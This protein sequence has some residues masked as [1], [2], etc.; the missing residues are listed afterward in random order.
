MQVL[1]GW[2]VEEYQHNSAAAHTNR[3]ENISEDCVNKSFLVT[4]LKTANL[5][6]DSGRLRRLVHRDRV[7][8]HRLRRARLSDALRSRSVC[9]RQAGCH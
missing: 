6:S 3:L 9:V 8:H 5:T 7:R 4:E 2:R 1:W